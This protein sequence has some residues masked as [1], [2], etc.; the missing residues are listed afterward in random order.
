MGTTTTFNN[1]I[2]TPVSKKIFL[3]EVNPAQ[4]Q[5][6]WTLTALQT[7]TYETSF[8][9]ETITLAD[10]TTET[11]R[12]VVSSI[13]E[14]GTALTEQSSIATV[15]ANAS[16]Y[17]HDTANGKLYVHCSDGADPD[18]HTIICF[19]WLYFATHGIVLNDKYYEP[20]LATRSIPSLNQKNSS[21]HWGTSTIG[22]GSVKLLNNKGFFDLIA[23][24]ILWT[25]KTVRV[26]M[27]GDNLAY[28]EYQALFT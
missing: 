17:W 9:N 27:G 23:A 3:V 16:S 22:F 13:E 7:Y 12:K 19:F 5:G 1:L 28:A 8:L 2:A 24:K 18:T 25:N 20:Y 21:V 6:G 26:L 15:E 14:D 10:N 11:I 4:E